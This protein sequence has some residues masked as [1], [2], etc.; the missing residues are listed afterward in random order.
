MRWWWRAVAVLVAGTLVGSETSADA[1]TPAAP[2]NA[3][4]TQ[5]VTSTRLPTAALQAYF[6]SERASG[7]ERSEPL[8]RALLWTAARSPEPQRRTWLL[9]AAQAD[10]GLPEPHLALLASALRRGDVPDV[11]TAAVA[12]VQ[13]VHRDARAEAR[14]L[15]DGFRAVHGLLTATLVTLAMLAALR[16]L[17]LVRHAL[18]AALGSD[19]A[20]ALLV[21]V[22]LVALFVHV[23]A[24]GSL[25][26]L[27]AITPFLRRREQI[28]LA[29]PCVLLAGLEIGLRWFAPHALLVD[30]RTR[31]AHIAHL[32]DRGHDATFEHELRA[33]PVRS[34][35]VELVLGL[36]AR[37][38]GDAAGASERF[39]A[40]LRADSTSAAAYLNLANVFFRAGDYG[41]AATG[42]RAAQSLA[43]ADPLAYANLAQTYIRMTQYANS[44]SELRAANARGIADV[45]RRRGLWRDDSQPVFD[46]TLSRGVLL[47]LAHAEVDRRPELR[48]ATLESWRSQ[49]WRGMRGGVA[50]VLLLMT[51]GWLVWGL[52]LRRI[53]V[54]CT[55]CSTILCTHCIAQLP[56]DDRCN[57]CQIARPRPRVASDD[58]VPPEKRRR[59]SLASGRWM[60]PLFP[61]AAD[62]VRGTPVA[63]LVAVACTWAAVLAAHAIVDAARLRVAPWW[64]DADL[65]AL[66]TAAVAVCLV[67]LPGLL[68]LRARE[69]ETRVTTTRRRGA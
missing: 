23:P 66:Q 60:A 44:D 9:L 30:P 64:V 21:L 35:E 1:T 43:P 33:E 51:A 16:S 40:A 57:T 17:R 5:G 10:P 68:R 36:Q 42:Y 34:A 19:S 22:P 29:V 53:A 27:A 63:A 49:P 52:R 38:R 25:L 24:I 18:G 8:A 50:P 62:L 41:R 2:A 32:N 47:D 48:G 54:A 61:G 4:A 45:N 69:L 58:L 20:A 46:A 31:S 6:E 55:E 13:A 65:R 12:A 15:R 28:V 7:A 56:G 11:C 37:R 26:V 67:W 3:V 59:V 14:A 39:L